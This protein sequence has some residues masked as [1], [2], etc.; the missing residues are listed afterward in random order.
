MESDKFIVGEVETYGAARGCAHP[1]PFTS[2][3]GLVQREMMGLAL[4]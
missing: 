1:H 2:V 3:S 4:D